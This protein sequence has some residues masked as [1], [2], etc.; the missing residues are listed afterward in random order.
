MAAGCQ[1]V[2][3]PDEWTIHHTPGEKTV[4]LQLHGVPPEKL[5]GLPPQVILPIRTVIG[6]LQK[7]KKNRQQAAKVSRTGQIPAG[8]DFQA[9]D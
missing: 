6:M 7:I 2:W 8:V 1:N 3:T 5:A 4:Y 9:M